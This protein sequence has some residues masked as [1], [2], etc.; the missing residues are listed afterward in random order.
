[1]MICMIVKSISVQSIIKI[2]ADADE[3]FVQNMFCLKLEKICCRV[4]TPNQKPFEVIQ[5]LGRA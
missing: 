4:P 2:G 3:C 1:M 5:P